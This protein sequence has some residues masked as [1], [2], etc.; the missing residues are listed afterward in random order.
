MDQQSPR[1]VLAR[2]TAYAERQCSFIGGGRE[3]ERRD[4]EGVRGS[5][6]PGGGD[7]AYTLVKLRRDSLAAQAVGVLSGET[8]DVHG[9]ISWAA[10]R[11]VP[12]AAGVLGA[13]S[14]SW[15]LLWVERRA[16]TSWSSSVFIL[17]SR[18]GKAPASCVVRVGPVCQSLAKSVAQL[19]LFLTAFATLGRPGSGWCGCWP[20]VQKLCLFVSGLLFLVCLQVDVDFVSKCVEISLGEVHLAVWSPGVERWCAIC[21]SKTV[22]LAVWVMHGRWRR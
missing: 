8:H 19:A 14:L 4:G 20:A 5:S 17:S 12:Q 1:V 22:A 3:G 16:W 13:R 6:S 18:L 11:A 9:T 2:H 7:P 15:V 10:F 21:A